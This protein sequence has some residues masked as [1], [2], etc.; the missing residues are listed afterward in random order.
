[1]WWATLQQRHLSRPASVRLFRGRAGPTHDHTSLLLSS[2]PFT[3]RYLQYPLSS[4]PELLCFRVP[5][6]FLLALFL[7]LPLT[8]LILSCL[9]RLRR[10]A[11]LLAL[12]VTDAALIRILLALF[13]PALPLAFPHGFF[14]F[15]II[16]IFFLAGVQA[17]KFSDCCCTLLKKKKK[18]SLKKICVMI[19][20][21]SFC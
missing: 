15:I 17:H 13:S 1:M 20:C 18:T 6:K 16:L 14:F 12:P 5:L 4:L 21:C 19:V 11:K 3:L 10:G 7:C 9:C 2:F 8:L